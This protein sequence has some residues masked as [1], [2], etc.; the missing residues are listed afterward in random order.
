MSVKVPLP[1]LRSS[2]S[3]APRLRRRAIPRNVRSR[4]PS[5]STSTKAA[6][7][8][9]CG[10]AGSPASPAHLRTCRSALWCS[11][12]CPD[13][14]PHEDI[15]AAVVVVVARDRSRRRSA[16]SV[17]EASGVRA[18]ANDPRGVSKQVQPVGP[19][20][21]DVEIAV[22]VDVD[23][24]DAPAPEPRGARRWRPA[25]ARQRVHVR[26]RDRRRVPRRPGRLRR[27]SRRSLRRTPLLEIG[28]R[29]G[30]A[31]RRC[32]AQ[33]FEPLHRGRLL[34]L[35]AGAGQGHRQ[36]V[37]GGRV[38][39][40]GGDRFAQKRRSPARIALLQC[41]PARD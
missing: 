18:S 41:R 2:W 24:H 1:L 28:L 22:A 19:A 6:D 33:R 29:V 37:G 13:A 25:E 21:E 32:A 30:H 23:E 7:A 16:A 8:D 34:A 27:R 11:S 39:R 38:V 10:N 3:A 20:L 31:R 9:R 35:V 26:E 12:R 5:W 36:A 15:G 40:L 14:V 17:A 4:S